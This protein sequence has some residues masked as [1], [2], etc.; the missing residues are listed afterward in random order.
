KLVGSDAAARELYV[1]MAQAQRQLLEDY[2]SAPKSAADKYGI[3][4]Q[5]LFQKLWGPNI[6]QRKQ[7]SQG[8]VAAMLLVGS[9]PEVAL[10][11]PT[12]VLTVNLLYQPAFNQGIRTGSRVEPLK[13]LLG[14]W[15]SQASG[16]SAVQMLNLAMQY[17]LKE[18]LDLGLRLIREKDFAS[19]MSI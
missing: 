13:K 12:R 5:A 19:G 1:E 18:G 16:Q 2:E 14:G 3:E 9:D 7:I 6:A 8:D 4:V 17:N 10:A 11:D 15:I